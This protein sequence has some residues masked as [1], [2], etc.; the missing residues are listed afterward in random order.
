MIQA[1]IEQKVPAWSP[2]GKWIAHWEGVEMTHMSKFTGV[3][4]RQRDQMISR[5]FHVW[6]VVSDGR[7]RRKVGRGDDPTWSPNSFVT[8]A[9]PD[10]KRGSPIV[11]V[12]TL[13]RGKGIAHRATGKKLGPIHL[14]AATSQEAMSDKSGLD[15]IVHYP[16]PTSR[17][18]WTS[19]SPSTLR[20]VWANSTRTSSP[21][22]LELSSID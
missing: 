10:P 16:A 12:E 13:I 22:L 4:N 6:V 17:S 11:I 2:D 15:R 7:N 21:A 1:P 3:R 9:F 14:G 8:R 18:S 19:C 5:T 20:R